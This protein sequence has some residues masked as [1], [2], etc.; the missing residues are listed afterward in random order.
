MPTRLL[1]EQQILLGER[2]DGDPVQVHLLPAGEFEK[3]VERSLETVHVDA[4]GR[5]AL[6]SFGERD[7]LE[8]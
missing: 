1:D 3:Q 8:R 2:Q 7:I 4:Q 5:L 6:R